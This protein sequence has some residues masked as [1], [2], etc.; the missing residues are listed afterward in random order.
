MLA[1]AVW[2]VSANNESSNLMA[3]EINAAD[4]A[5]L[6]QK[7]VFIKKLVNELAAKQKEVDGLKTALADIKNKAES[8]KA[9]P[10]AAK[11]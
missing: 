9:E 5:I 2:V 10:A 8:V 3:K 4:S 11:M 1:I 6:Q 7:N